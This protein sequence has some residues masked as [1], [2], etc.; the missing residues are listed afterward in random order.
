MTGPLFRPFRGWRFSASHHANQGMIVAPPYDVIAPGDIGGLL[1]ASPHNVI[2]LELP[3]AVDASNPYHTA[4]RTWDEWTSK[5]VLERETSPRFYLV[6]HTFQLDGHKVSRLEL[7]GAVRLAPWEDGSV[8]PHEQTHEAA[9]LD[10]LLLMNSVRANISPIM[11]LYENTANEM[12]RLLMDIVSR[13]ADAS[14]TDLT[15]DEY[16]VWN[17]SEPRET[18]ALTSGIR[19]PLYI[20][21]GHHRYE[22]ALTYR[23][24]RRQE[25]GD[26][27]LAAGY[28]MA[29]L[30]ATDDT[31]LISLPYH[32]LIRGLPDDAMVRLR[33][34]IETYFQSEE[35]DIGGLSA[36]ESARRFTSAMN[37]APNTSLM[38]VIE[39]PG[40]TLKLLSPTEQ[41]VFTGLLTGE[42]E[43]WERLAPCVFLDILLLHGVGVDQQQ[44]EDRGWLTYPR[45]AAEAIEAV[46]SGEYDA[47]LLLKAV[48]ITDMTESAAAGERLPPKSTYFFPKVA[49]GIVMNS[50]AGRLED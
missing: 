42:T 11:A 43:A 23:D 29:A 1:D 5:G 24:D 20:A 21:D 17:V 12:R 19:G 6:R 47:G 48:G 16:D 34:Q 15:G 46:R 14:F 4:A 13:P 7:I 45:D 25:D 49:T 36:S 44:A 26:G 33:R 28:V 10:R 41:G 9:K 38:A 27:N 2:R 8:L 32:R 37:D 35:I 31:G 22:T 30:T 18:R 3:S 40:D 39:S 50:L